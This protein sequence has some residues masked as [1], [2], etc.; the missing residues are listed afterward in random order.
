ML[1]DGKLY[2]AK[3]VDWVSVKRFKATVD[4]NFPPDESLIESPLLDELVKAATDYNYLSN[5][6][7]R[8]PRGLGS[9]CR[10]RFAEVQAVLHKNHAN[11]AAAPLQEPPP[12]DIQVIIDK[13]IE[14]GSLRWAVGF[15]EAK[16]PLNEAERNSAD[17]R[18]VELQDELIGI[19][20]ALVKTTVD[21]S[22]L[23]AM[24]N[25]AANLERLSSITLQRLQSLSKGNS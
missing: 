23:Q 13:I 19:Y 18:C 2:L 14:F 4:E 8:D 21:P 20:T 17:A 15:N 12:K 3:D 5:E 16:L 6:L 1:E 25:T 24:I 7:S 9:W 22:V 10:A 11:R